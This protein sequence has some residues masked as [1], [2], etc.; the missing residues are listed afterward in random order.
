[1]SPTYAADHIFECPSLRQPRFEILEFYIKQRKMLLS[2]PF[3]EEKAV[4]SRKRL[5]KTADKAAST[6]AKLQIGVQGAPVIVQVEQADLR[7]IANNEQEMDEF[8]SD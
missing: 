1:M 6:Q 5:V 7:K 4:N 2:L 3:D 8:A